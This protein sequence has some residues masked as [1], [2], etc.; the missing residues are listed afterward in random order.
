MSYE[1]EICLKSLFISCMYS[2]IAYKWIYLSWIFEVD[3]HSSALYW[4]N[5]LKKCLI[6]DSVA[7]FYMILLLNLKLEISSFIFEIIEFY[8]CSYRYPI[9]ALQKFL[10]IFLVFLFSSLF[11]KFWHTFFFLKICFFFLLRNYF[12]EIFPSF[13]SLLFNEPSL[14]FVGFDSFFVLQSLSTWLVNLKL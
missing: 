3:I 8:L 12:W 14:E 6:V 5:F 7:I 13:W 1:S 11:E 10:A 2:L 4:R 9:K